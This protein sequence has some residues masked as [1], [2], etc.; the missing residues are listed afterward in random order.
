MTPDDI[1][2]KARAE[3][4]KAV[5]HTLHEFN[6]IHTG[7]ASPA[8]V[9]N[10][11]VDVYG[12]SMRL[13]EVAAITTPDSRTISIQPWDK[14]TLQPIEKAIQVANLGLNPV[15]RG[16]SIICPLPELSGERRKELVK[17]THTLAES[18]RVGVRAARQEAMHA[19][20]EALKN[21]EISE[22]DEKRGEKDVQAETDKFVKSIEEHLKA[23]EAELT[24]V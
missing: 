21:K 17:M 23:K 14:G 9:E 10:V 16:Q 12:S 13:M 11:S 3:M 15:V 1:L 7:K 24:T 6:S 19:L 18:G 8:M 4:Q 22:D 5:D 2:K 20:K